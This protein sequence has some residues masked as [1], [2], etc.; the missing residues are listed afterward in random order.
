MAPCALAG[1]DPTV[2][3]EIRS[4]PVPVGSGARALG[5]GGAFIAIADDAT[6]AS[7][8]PGGLVQLER[9]EISAVGAFFSRTDN[10]QIGVD[11]ETE[12][13]ET[14]SD[15]RL[16]YLS[17]VVPFQLIHRNM[18]VSVNFQNL[19]DF[20]TEQEF[21]IIDS[22][23]VDAGEEQRY[24]YKS[25]GSLSAIGI[26]YAVQVTPRMSI[27]VTLN[28]WQDSIYDNEWTEQRSE[29]GSG[30]DA[31]DR[32]ESELS[33]EDTYKF[34]GLN[35]NLGILWQ[36]SSS[37]TLGA[38]LKTPFEA[39][40]EHT[41]TLDGTIQFPD[42]DGFDTTVSDEDR[43]DGT[44]SMPVSY[45]V[46]IAYRFSDILTLSLDLFRTEWDDY[47]FTDED[48]DKLSPIT[49][50][51][52]SESDVDATHLVRMGAEYLILK[53]KYIFP[54]R[55]GL[56]M[57]QAPAEGNPDN[58]YGFSLGSGIARGR[59]VFDAAYQ[60]RFGR[61][62]GASG[63]EAWDFSQDTDEHIV[64]ASMIIYF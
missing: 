48:G 21:T 14:V 3:A 20:T 1:F 17:A 60:Y 36:L 38:V 27:G 62:V 47:V 32:F 56:F 43:E 7:W 28:I 41:Y 33:T 25:D 10:I 64:Y 11:S 23:G 55:G 18:V 31:G 15:S 57:D 37:F 29:S 6:A 24:N 30:T 9:S 26:A 61:D 51:L 44:L 46:G 4:T 39:D 49:G 2:L 19:Y 22:T 53:G 5:M 63:R 13:P 8:N 12:G 58:Y 52:P 42:L 50:K 45:G 54:L 34:S 35:A 59:T 40:V 16:N